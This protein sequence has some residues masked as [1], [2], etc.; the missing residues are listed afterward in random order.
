MILNFDGGSLEQVRLP[1]LLT[2][3]EHIPAR[4]L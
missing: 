1:V 4:L 3:V 2:L